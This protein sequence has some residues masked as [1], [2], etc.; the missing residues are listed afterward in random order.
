MLQTF[1]SFFF[2]SDTSVELCHSLGTC[3]VLHNVC[4]SSHSQSITAFPPFCSSFAT[5]LSS[6]TDFPFRSSP[7][8]Y[9]IPSLVTTG[10][11]TCKWST[12]PDNTSSAAVLCTFSTL[13]KCLFQC[14]SFSFAF[15]RGWLVSSSIVS[16]GVTLLLVSC[17]I[18]LKKSPCQWCIMSASIPCEVSSIYFSLSSHT[19]LLTFLHRSTYSTI[20]PFSWS[21]CQSRNTRHCARLSPVYPLRSIS[22]ALAMSC[23]GA[24]LPGPLL[25]S[26]VPSIHLPHCFLLFCPQ[27]IY[28]W[29]PC[30]PVI[31][32]LP[33]K[34]GVSDAQATCIRKPTNLPFLDVCLSR[35]SHHYIL[36]AL[37]YGCIEVLHHH[38]L[39]VGIAITWPRS[40]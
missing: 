7:T 31:F 15:W 35:P 29:T 30:T 25:F 5:I 1:L 8:F 11:S 37:I 14:A 9:F 12:M 24:P 6:P 4:S 33:G 20:F 23:V 34:D 22:S 40:E 39:A 26:A 3:L 38:G 18:F 2:W 36:H 13:S 17:F 27:N 16:A 21:S 10:L 19:F 32:L 28:R